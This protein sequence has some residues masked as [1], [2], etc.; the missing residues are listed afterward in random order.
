MEFRQRFTR[1]PNRCPLTRVG[2]HERRAR[3]SHSR[4]FQRYFYISLTHISDAKIEDLEYIADPVTGRDVIKSG[5]PKALVDA[6]LFPLNQD[7]TY[8]QEFLS[9]YRF[10]MSAQEVLDSLIG[11]YNVDLQEGQKSELDFL[12]K[13]RRPI[14]NKVV[15]LLLLWINHHWQDFLSSRVLS[16]DLSVFV[17]YLSQV[18]YGDHQKLTQGIREQVCPAIINC[19]GSIGIRIFMSPLLFQWEPRSRLIKPCAV[20][21]WRRTLT[22][23]LLIFVLLINFIFDRLNKMHTCRFCMDLSTSR[24]APFIQD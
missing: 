20:T 12:R 1:T 15:S 5:T 17:H 4:H 3:L 22:I 24:A 19:S 8:A 7:S 10:F 16:K 9:G 13:H 18:S 14:Q 2:Y 11:W 23:S 6:L 21:F